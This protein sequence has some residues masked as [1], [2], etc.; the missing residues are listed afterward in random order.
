MCEHFH[1]YKPRNGPK[2]CWHQGALC[3]SPIMKRVLRAQRQRR[4]PIPQLRTPQYSN[5]HHCPSTQSSSQSF[6]KAK[7]LYRRDQQKITMYT[8]RNPNWQRPQ[9]EDAQ[10]FRAEQYQRAWALQQLLPTQH[11]GGAYIPALQANPTFAV[12]NM[13]SQPQ[14][15][16]NDT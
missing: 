3:V 13:L 15:P 14:K 16:I 12:A 2:S 5:H 4:S 10:R 11:L 6:S 8:N 9:I 1:G 7:Y